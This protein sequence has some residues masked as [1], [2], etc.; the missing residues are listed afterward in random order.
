MHGLSFFSRELSINTGR[1]SACTD[2]KV[3]QEQKVKIA[4]IGDPFQGSERNVIVWHVTTMN[5]TRD[6]PMMCPQGFHQVQIQV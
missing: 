5:R 6:D 3:Y 1:S 4:S 2:S